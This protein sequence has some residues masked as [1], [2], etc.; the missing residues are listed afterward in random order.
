MDDGTFAVEAEIEATHWWFVGRRKLFSRLITSLEQSSN[1]SVLDIGCST[2]TNLRMLI[3]NKFI[4]VSGIDISPVAINWCD[5]KGLPKVT[6]GSV[7]NIPFPDS[8]FDLVLATDIIEHVDDDSLAIAEIQRVLKPGGYVLITV[9]AFN[10][11]W[12]LQDR[13]SHHKRRYKIN[14]LLAIVK[15]ADLVPIKYF[16]FNFILFIPIW[17][18]RQIINLLGINIRSEGEVN[19][20]IISSLLTAIF[21]LDIWLSP[22]V[23]PPFG[24]SALVLAG[25]S[26]GFSR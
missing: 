7:T 5:L 4:N 8:F 17:I 13:V 19:G 2:G 23:R 22:I 26:H 1:I 14:N 20:P 15:D 10:M 18:A 11:L 12:G 16:Y 24:V 9:P 6:L 21:F 25:K 3:E